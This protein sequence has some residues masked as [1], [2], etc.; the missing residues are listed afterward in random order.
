MRS[1]LTALILGTAVLS[2]APAFSDAVKDGKR[3]Y[4]TKS[5]MA[6]H[7]R[8]GAKPISTC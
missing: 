4:M 5:C 8:N 7:G 1:A 3:V 6:C 2:A